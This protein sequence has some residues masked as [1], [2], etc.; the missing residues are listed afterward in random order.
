MFRDSIRNFVD[1]TEGAQ[2]GLLMDLEGIAVETYAREGSSCDVE[3]V[4]AEASVV[5]KAIQRAGEMLDV[6]PMREISFQSDDMTTLIRI[7]NDNYFVALTLGPGG[8]IGKGRYML[9]TAAPQLANE[10]V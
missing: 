6:G 7:L 1:N 3:V 10:L 8:N 9:R 5:V 4:G 2:A